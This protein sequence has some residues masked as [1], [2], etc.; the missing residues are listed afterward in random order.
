MT[1]VEALEREGQQDEAEQ[2]PE[3]PP[4]LPLDEDDA[5]SI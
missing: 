1:L 3:M 4:K 2:P 5:V